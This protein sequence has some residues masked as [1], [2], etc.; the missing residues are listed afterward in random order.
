MKRGLKFSIKLASLTLC[1]ISLA[2]FSLVANLQIS[3]VF[4]QGAGYPTPAFKYTTKV[5][6]KV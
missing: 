3:E 1:L 6:S 5:A 4:D 2:S